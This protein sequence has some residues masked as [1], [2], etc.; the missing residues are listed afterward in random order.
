ME[1]K[2]VTITQD[3]YD[4]LIRDQVFLDM[5]RNGGVANWDWYDD[6]RTAF[7]EWEESKDA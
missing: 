6:V 2:S 5:L 7:E 4:E 1:I 3:E